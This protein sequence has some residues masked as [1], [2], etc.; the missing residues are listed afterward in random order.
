[1]AMKVPDETALNRCSLIPF[2][3]LA[4]SCPWQH[5]VAAGFA[6]GLCQPSGVG[7]GY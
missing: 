5:P 2:S 6:A 7:V 4:H 3:A 1:M